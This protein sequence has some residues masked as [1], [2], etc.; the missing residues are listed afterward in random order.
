MNIINLY[1]YVK[2]GFNWELLIA[3]A[4]FVISCFLSIIAYKFSLNEKKERYKRE[5]K[6]YYDLVFKY[7]SEIKNCY[8]SI[9]NELELY[10]NNKKT[11]QYKDTYDEIV[12]NY[13]NSNN[14]LNIINNRIIDLNYNDSCIR[15]NKMY[16]FLQQYLEDCQKDYYCKFYPDIKHIKEEGI[17]KINI[18]DEQL[19]TYNK[20]FKKYE[21]NIIILQHKYGK[22]FFKFDENGCCLLKSLFEENLKKFIDSIWI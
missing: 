3:F 18:D 1:N 13:E 8:S 15:F 7:T 10:L 9:S 5:I 12:K 22:L 4:D 14:E 17:E 6:E 11:I 2:E 20:D 21:N 16:P 19:H